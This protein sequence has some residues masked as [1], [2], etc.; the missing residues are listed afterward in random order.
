[1]VHLSFLSA[2]LLF[3]GYVRAAN[4]WSKPCHDGSCSYDVKNGTVSGTM[5][6]VSPCSTVHASF[7]LLTILFMD[8]LDH[9]RRFRTSHLPAD[10]QSSTAMQRRVPKTSELYVLAA[11][12]LVVTSIKAAQWEHLFACQRTCVLL[13]CPPKTSFS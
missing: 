10:G 9:Q 4:D 2:T 5:L 8:S 13:F 11:T 3:I 6:I 12:P 1:M 7:H